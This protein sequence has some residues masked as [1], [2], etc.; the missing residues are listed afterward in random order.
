MT[1]TLFKIKL[2]RENLFV[3]ASD[4]EEA[5]WQAVELSREHHSELVD[6]IPV[7]ETNG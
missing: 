4:I 1:E 5:A 7:D 2:K 6:I 3:V